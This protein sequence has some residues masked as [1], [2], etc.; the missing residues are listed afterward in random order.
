VAAAIEEARKAKE[1]EEEKVILLSVSAKS[2]LDFGEKQRYL[3]V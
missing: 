2:Y 3:R 1:V